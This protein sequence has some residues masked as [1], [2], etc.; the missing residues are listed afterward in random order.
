MQ[1]HLLGLV[2]QMCCFQY[3]DKENTLADGTQPCTSCNDFSACCAAVLGFAA[4]GAVWIATCFI[5]GA[6]APGVKIECKPCGGTGLV[7]RKGRKFVP[8]NQGMK[9]DASDAAPASATS[10]LPGRL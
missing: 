7:V 4:C 5:C 9:R 3:N 1:P 10:R 2:A 8:S 6:A